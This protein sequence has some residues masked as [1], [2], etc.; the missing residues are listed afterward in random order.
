MHRYCERAAGERGNPKQPFVIARPKA[1]AILI[2]LLLI[3][4]PVFAATYS[5]T[6]YTLDNA[7]IAITGGPASSTN[8]AL[9]Y[10]EAGALFCGQAQSANYSFTTTPSAIVYDNPPQINDVSVTSQANFHRDWPLVIQVDAEDVDGDQLEYRYLANGQ[11]IQS[12]TT[13]SQIEWAHQ[14]GDLGENDIEVEVRSQDATS[15]QAPKNVHV[16]RKPI[17]TE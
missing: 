15:N 9:D 11:E 13:Q 7:K 3:A 2:I 8:Y 1:A 5:S 17:T 10:V 12:W 16:F 14:S 4:T 6:N